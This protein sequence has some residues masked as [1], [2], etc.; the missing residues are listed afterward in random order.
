MTSAQSMQSLRPGFKRGVIAALIVLLMAAGAP[1]PAC[2]SKTPL[3]APATLASPYPGVQLWAVAPFAN[4]SGVSSVD[5]QRIAD[6]FVEEIEQAEGLN[7]VAVNRAI[8]AM[9]RLD[10][11]AV[12]TPAHAASLIK[13]LGV[14]GL[15]VGTVTAYD[16]Y[17]PLKFG[18]AIQL[19]R[20]EPG[21]RNDIDP[22]A[23]TRSRSEPASP[24]ALR[25]DVPA[26][27]AS[28]VFDASNH[29]VIQ[30]REQY[31]AGRA[32]PGSAYGTAI[33]TVDMELYTQFVAYRLLHDLLQAERARTTPAA[34]QPDTP[35]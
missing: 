25:S 35:R 22:V 3:Q 5:T 10:M 30:W 17:Q 7:A 23:M 21:H 12:A 2:S 1:L 32:V 19:Y 4:E 15:I 28:G 8:A 11:A 34:T 18:A 20:G 16:P 24:G 31:A 29:Q 26:A 6:H 14:D 9:R 33:Y 13:A 27:Q